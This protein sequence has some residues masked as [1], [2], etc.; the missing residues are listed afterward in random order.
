MFEKNM[1]DVIVQDTP[2]DLP[3]IENISK[4]HDQLQTLDWEVT[5]LARQIKIYMY[6]AEQKEKETISLMCDPY[7]GWSQYNSLR[8][9][10]IDGLKLADY[11]IKWAK[12]SIN[13]LEIGNEK[14]SA[15]IKYSK[16]QHRLNKL[17][18][19]VHP[20]REWRNKR[21][22][23]LDPDDHQ[24]I[25]NVSC[26]L[27]SLYT[28][29]AN[30]RNSLDYIRHYIANPHYIYSGK[31]DIFDTSDTET[32]EHSSGLDRYFEIDPAIQALKTVLGTSSNRTYKILTALENL[33]EALTE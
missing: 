28:A 30:L 25:K 7:F 14:T 13:S 3:T 32:N 18:S 11:S 19:I 24:E 12:K 22:A 27:E 2:A 5:C 16:I 8:Q 1:T 26:N 33:R 31:W 15:L 23:H 4:A 29:L 9:F 20:L 10:A 6:V 21:Y 17:R